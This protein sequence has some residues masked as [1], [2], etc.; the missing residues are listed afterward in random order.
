MENNIE[1]TRKKMESSNKLIGLNHRLKRKIRKLTNEL[2]SQKEK[3][4]ALLNQFRYRV[5][6]EL[7]EHLKSKRRLARSSRTN[8]SEQPTPLSE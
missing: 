1:E 8:H 5:Q 4:N 3:M 2:N 6:S 7:F